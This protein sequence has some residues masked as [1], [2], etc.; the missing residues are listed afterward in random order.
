MRADLQIHH[1]PGPP[2]GSSPLH[3]LQDLIIGS[4]LFE[5]R[6]IEL[7]LLKKLQSGL[8]ALLFGVLQALAPGLEREIVPIGERSMC[9]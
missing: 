7:A 9:N 1:P 5:E 6:H 3:V 2:P 4:E 8:L